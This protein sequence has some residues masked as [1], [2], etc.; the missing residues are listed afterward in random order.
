MV[1]ETE[2]KIEVKKLVLQIGTRE[3][4]L[5]PAEAEKLHGALNQLFGKPDV[6]ARQTLIIK[7]TQVVPVPT[8]PPYNPQPVWY[9]NYPMVIGVGDTT[10]QL[11]WTSN[12]GTIYG[13]F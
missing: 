7:E 4:T 13:T 8:Y 5:T 9:W 1:R 6:P 12:G 3:L 2:K 10:T 11:T